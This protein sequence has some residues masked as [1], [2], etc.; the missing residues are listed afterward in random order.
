MA[1]TSQLEQDKLVELL[2]PDASQLPDLRALIGFLG[3]STR[4]GYWRLYSTLVLDEYVEFS[5]TDVVHAHVVNR[6][7]GKLGGTVVWLRRHANLQQTRTI[8]REA[9]AD[10]LHGDIAAAFLGRSAVQ[11]PAA[12]AGGIAP[13]FMA[14]CL[15]GGDFDT[16]CAAC[17]AVPTALVAPEI[18]RALAL[19]P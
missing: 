15:T 2:A 9:Q 18:G 7:H 14:A 1:H 19:G 6:N 3:R 8:S 17:T 13:W 11:R 16:L 4:Q 12:T 5:E 10:F